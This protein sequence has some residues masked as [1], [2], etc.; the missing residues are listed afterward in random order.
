M[1]RIS[2][3]AI[4]GK[5]LD[6]CKPIRLNIGVYI[7]GYGAK[8]SVGELYEI[9][10]A[11]LYDH[12]GRQSRG[13]PKLQN[14]LYDKYHTPYSPEI[15]AEILSFCLALVELDVVARIE[16]RYRAAGTKLRPNAL[17]VNQSNPLAIEIDGRKHNVLEALFPVA[18][19]QIKAD[20]YLDVTCKGTIYSPKNINRQR[21]IR[22][23]SAELSKAKRIGD[24]ERVKWIE[25]NLET[26][27]KGTLY[28]YD[29]RKK[30][31]GKAINFDFTERFYDAVAKRVG[32]SRCW[33]EMKVHWGADLNDFKEKGVDC[34]LIMDVMDDLHADAVDAFVFMTNDMDFFPLIERLC[35]EGKPVFLCGLKC[36]VSQRLIE[37]AGHNQF[38]DLANQP[39]RD[40]LPS[41]FMAAKEGTP[42]E[43]LLQLTFLSIL[44]ERYA[45]G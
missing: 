6:G 27:R 2:G 34:N 31:I 32:E 22:D 20:Q 16:E 25:R 33:G 19:E 42:R 1:E 17:L 11:S 35:H 4:D 15:Y 29:R 24:V 12:L 13:D 26:I 41:V 3:H 45:G 8:L 18:R 43:S 10:D 37:A 23:L 30:S 28:Y 36:K 38:I 40:R 44:H 7:D 5:H 39:L 14:D 9:G 21:Q